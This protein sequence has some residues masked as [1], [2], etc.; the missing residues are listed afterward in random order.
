MAQI[1]VDSTVMRDKAQTITTE[2]T[3]IQSRYEE[4]LQEV[5]SMASK[6]RGTTIETAQK[7]FAGM[8]NVFQTIVEDMKKYGT[9]LTEAAEAYDAAEQK[10]I[11]KAQE[12][13]RVF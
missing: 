10:G 4:M 7:Q 9:F 3:T 5:N 11:Q 2:A 6:M 12:Q 8:Q 1:V 13:G